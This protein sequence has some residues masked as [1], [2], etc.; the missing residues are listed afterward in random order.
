MKRVLTILVL[1]LLVPQ[2]VSAGALDK[3][4]SMLEN[5]SCTIKYEIAY[6]DKN[7]KN[8]DDL[9]IFY[10]KV[11]DKVEAENM[12]APKPMGIIVLQGEN[13]YTQNDGYCLLTR[14]GYEYPYVVATHKGKVDYYG[15]HASVGASFHSVKG[16]PVNELERLTYGVTYGDE[17][18]TTIMRVICPET[19]A[20]NRGKVYWRAA[21]GS[22]EGGISYEDYQWAGDNG[23]VD[24]MR[25][26][27]NA[28]ELTK[29]STVHY[30]KLGPNRVAGMHTTIKF[31]E[32]SSTPDEKYLTLPSRL[33]DVTKYAK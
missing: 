11:M 7:I 25:F 9:G 22:L 6:Q 29:V 26:Y 21:S 8:N 15:N 23:D 28:G 20:L 4:R 19:R 18:I 2:I 32:F 12:G 13:S 31:H 24:L 16:A 17:E 5:R 33:K 27:F 3:Y 1:F 14:N 10:Q 30:E